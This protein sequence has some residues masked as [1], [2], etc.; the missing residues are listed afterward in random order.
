[1]FPTWYFLPFSSSPVCLTL[2]WYCKEKWHTGHPWDILEVKSLW[3]R[4]DKEFENRTF[5]YVDP[6]KFGKKN[7]ILYQDKAL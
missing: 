2:F 4:G 5:S 6:Y 3:T 7:L 1:M